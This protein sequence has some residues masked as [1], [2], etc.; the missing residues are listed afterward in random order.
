MTRTRS[1]RRSRPT[2]PFQAAPALLGVGALLLWAGSVRAQTIT[3][4]GPN[5][6]GS[7]AT[8][9]GTGTAVTGTNTTFGGG[10]GPG[11]SSYQTGVV[12]YGA[13]NLQ[14]GG[15]FQNIT[16]GQFSTVNISGGTVGAVSDQPGIT[17][18]TSTVNI[19][20]GTVT[21]VTDDRGRINI[22]GGT[23]QNVGTDTFDAAQTGPITISGGNVQSI[24]TPGSLAV[25]G[26]TLGS[27]TAFFAAISGGTIQ[28]LNI[29]GSSPGFSG[30]ANISGGSFQFITNTS[31]F[32]INTVNITGTNLQEIGTPTG[33]NN[34]GVF[35]LIGL[36]S[37]GETL[38]AQYTQ[39]GNNTQLQFNG[40][41]ATPTP[42]P[43][44]S[45]IAS[46]GGMLLLGG[47]GLAFRARKRAG[48]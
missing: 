40:V 34:D 5:G 1:Y 28:T 45:T 11:T 43:E 19:S 26:G 29:S 15:S 8:V 16:A 46:L 42:V 13:L 7:S 14:N 9:S 27:A 35:R 30:G 33:A 24:N 39:S 21:T 18:Q 44:V 22:S 10:A 4:S 20:G 41:R 38:D 3:L 6:G 47:A 23:V 32:G 12:S 25:S 48:A 31:L 37:D 36:L 2:P 17:S